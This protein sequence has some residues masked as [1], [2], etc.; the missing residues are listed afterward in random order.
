MGKDLRALGLQGGCRTD[1]VEVLMGEEEV[2]R[3]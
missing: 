2:G 1:V 3:F